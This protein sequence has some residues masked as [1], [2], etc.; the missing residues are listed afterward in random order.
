MKEIKIFNDID[1][2]LNELNR[3][4]NWDNIYRDFNGYLRLVEDVFQYKHPMEIQGFIC[5]IDEFYP[6]D[7]ENDEIRE[8]L[9]TM[10]SKLESYLEK[11]D[12]KSV[13][14]L[15][16]EKLLG[17]LYSVIFLISIRVDLEKE[18]P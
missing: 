13:S 6:E 7:V 8:F 2:F 15:Q 5:V 12:G 16:N 1:E 3:R 17:A 18:H 14:E 10:K 11:N 9:F 4:I